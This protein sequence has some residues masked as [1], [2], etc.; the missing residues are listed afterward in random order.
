MAVDWQTRGE[1]ALAHRFYRLTA[2]QAAAAAVPAAAG[3]CELEVD[4]ERV[5]GFAQHT[6]VRWGRP[7][8]LSPAVYATA[9]DADAHAEAWLTRD[10]DAYYAGQEG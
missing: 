8:L 6:P 1:G 10:R 4:G 5:F 9:A 3:V 2:E 7:L